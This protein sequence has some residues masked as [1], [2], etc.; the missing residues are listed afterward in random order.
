MLVV[1]SFIRVLVIIIIIVVEAALFCNPFRRMSESYRCVHPKPSRRVETTKTTQESHD[2]G[3]PV[4]I[5]E[6]EEVVEEEEE[7]GHNMAPTINFMVPLQESASR[8]DAE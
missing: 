1:E 4:P 8:N 5:D 3:F 7:A 2:E 6:E